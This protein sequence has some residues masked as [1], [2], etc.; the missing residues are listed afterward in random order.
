MKPCLEE[1]AVHG[2]EG[3]CN[4]DLGL[5]KIIADELAYQCRSPAMVAHASIADASVLSAS[6]SVLSNVTAEGYPGK[7][8]HAGAEN[9]APESRRAGFR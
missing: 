3:I 4:S 1:F 2:A 6:G 7:R 9:G 8:Y 5:A